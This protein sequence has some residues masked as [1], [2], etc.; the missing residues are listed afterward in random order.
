MKYKDVTP[1][2]TVSRIRMLLDK[3]GVRMREVQYENQGL[4]YSNR[5]SIDNPG[6]ETLDIGTNGKGM[7]YD[8]SM[9]S[10]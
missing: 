3:V 6:F 4:S 8:L 7:S 9:A 2:V 5:I 1:D 10:G